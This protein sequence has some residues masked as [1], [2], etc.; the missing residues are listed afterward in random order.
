MFEYFLQIIQKD[1]PRSLVIRARKL[2]LIVKGA[3]ALA[4]EVLDDRSFLKR[5]QDHRVRREFLGLLFQFLKR[6]PRRSP[7][8]AVTV[9]NDV[10]DALDIDIVITKYWIVLKNPPSLRL[11]SPTTSRMTLLMSSRTSESRLLDG[12]KS[13]KI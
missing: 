3:Y 2:Y 12:G 1:V 6:D 11:S 5:R 7:V 8:T 4:L 9:R 13:I 10:L